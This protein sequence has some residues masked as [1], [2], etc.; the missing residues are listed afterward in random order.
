MLI[1]AIFYISVTRFRNMHFGT[2]GN[3]VVKIINTR[4]NIL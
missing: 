4:I 1:T 3:K 2:D